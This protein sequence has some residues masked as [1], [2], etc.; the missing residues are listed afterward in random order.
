VIR[1]ALLITDML[2]DFVNG[3]IRSPDAR[4]IIAP[5][6]ALSS[7]ARLHRFPVI[8]ICDSHF[9]S[10]PEISVWGRHAMRGS[11]GA[12]IIP[13]LAP[14]KQD[15]VLEKRV[16]SAFHETGLDLLLRDLQIESVLVTGVATEI[17]VRHTAADA[18]M[19]GFKIGIPADCVGALKRSNQNK[20]LTYMSEMYGAKITSSA[21]L[22]KNWTQQK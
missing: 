7:A 22:I 5:L 3:K 13:E 9:P 19:H 16:Y 12:Q 21:E 11:F 17:C 18:F 15:F 10:D 6:A 8:Y 1:E 20:V 14:K 4:K 2:E